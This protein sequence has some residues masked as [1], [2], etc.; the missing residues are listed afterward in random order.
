MKIE[1]M[2]ADG[3]AEVLP[4]A[5]GEGAVGEMREG[6]VCGGFIGFGEP[7]AM[8]REGLLCHEAS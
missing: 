5:D 7:A 8:R 4:I 3:D 2:R 1:E 6:E